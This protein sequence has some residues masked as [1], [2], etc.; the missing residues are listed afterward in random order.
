MIREVADDRKE[1]VTDEGSGVSIDA[2][3]KCLEE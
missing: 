1:A 3:G 2:G